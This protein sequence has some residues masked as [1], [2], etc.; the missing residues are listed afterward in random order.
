MCHT[1][2]NSPPVSSR[3]DAAILFN[4]PQA[5]KMWYILACIWLMRIVLYR[6]VWIFRS[7]KKWIS[8]QQESSDL[9]PQVFSKDDYLL[10]KWL[11]SDVFTITT[12]VCLVVPNKS[13]LFSYPLLDYSRYVL[14]QNLNAK[15]S[16]VILGEVMLSTSLG[17]V[18][19]STLGEVMSSTLGE[20]MLST[21]RLTTES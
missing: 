21:Y 16:R 15:A 2:L 18:M 20:V 5:F 17:E 12:K 13:S 3:W 6:S 14:K 7:S 11:L 19:S 8:D 1:S 10:K 4:S 9:T